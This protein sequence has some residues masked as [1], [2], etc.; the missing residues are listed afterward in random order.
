MDLVIWII[1]RKNFQS[2]KQ[3]MFFIYIAKCMLK[4]LLVH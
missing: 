1:L 3:N 4:I 2:F